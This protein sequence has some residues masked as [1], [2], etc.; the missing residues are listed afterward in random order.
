MIVLAFELLSAA[1]LA[2][3]A[4]RFGSAWKAL[5]GTRRTAT[6]GGEA[7]PP[8][9]IL[10]P[11][12]GVDDRLLDNLS[13][14]C[15]L[16]YPEYEIVFC[17]QGASD[18]ALRVARK[19]KEMHPRR[20]IS[21]V[22]A[23]CREGLNPKVN[24]MIPG[25]AVARHPFVLISDSNVAPG[26]GYLREAM[27]H[28]RDP[29][30]GMVTHL[31]RGVGAKTLGARLES[32]H[33]NSFILPSVCLLDRVFSM[34]CVVGKSMLMRRSDLEELGGLR[35]VKDFLA[36]DYVL[37]ERFHRAGKKVAV[38]S[39]PVDTVNVYRT[40]RQFLS[41]HARWNRMRFSIA[42]PAYF[43]E[44]L[45][46]PV[47]LSLLMVA[48]TAGNP[49][50]VRAAAAVVAAKTALDAGLFLLLG[51]RASARWALLGPARDLFAL[52]LWFSAFF[53]REVEWRGRTLRIASGSRL[54]PVEDVPVLDPEAKGVTG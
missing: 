43:A 41:R 13:A 44:L 25:Y 16:D 46:N 22:I 30:V 14:F 17:V 15:R 21:I 18:P 20:E 31:V 23:D 33:L 51:D 49:G 28:F 35:G 26:A 4:V 32:Q 39:S 10:K 8:V 38:S 6:E 19:V 29:E 34:P 5:G 40:V 54:V 27:S 45:A 9:S 37:G 50:A 2:A 24:N 11:L 52:G 1:S 48:A 36:E 12:K 3:C 7:F 42:G 47:G 53:S